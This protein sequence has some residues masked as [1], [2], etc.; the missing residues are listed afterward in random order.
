MQTRENMHDHLGKYRV[1]VAPKGPLHQNLSRF[2]RVAL[3]D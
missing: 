2:R 1:C 3:S